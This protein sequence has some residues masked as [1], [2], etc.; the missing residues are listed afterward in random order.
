MNDDR[1]VKTTFLNGILFKNPICMQ[2][3]GIFPVITAGTTMKMGVVLSAINAVLLFCTSLLSALLFH[4]LPGWL[5]QVCYM[6][7]GAA[8]LIPIGFIVSAGAPNTASAIALFIPLMAVNSILF[9]RAESLSVQQSVF[10]AVTDSLA[11]GLG[12]GLVLTGVSAVRE[13]LGS[14]TIWGISLPWDR[15]AEGILLPFGGLIVLGFLAASF[16][17]ITTKI[18]QK[19]NRMGEG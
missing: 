9:K 7:T 6:I 14:T 17:W 13:I 15:R 16:Q 1:S 19:Q 4:N 18:K 11:N 5:R 8:L 2:A 10:A 3:L 12:Y